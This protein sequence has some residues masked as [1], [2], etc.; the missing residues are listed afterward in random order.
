ML[1]DAPGLA[2][3]KVQA[4]TSTPTRTL[5][6]STSLS[7]TELSPHLSSTPFFSLKTY[8]GSHVLRGT[9]RG[10]V[11]PEDMW[12]E[13]TMQ[14]VPTEAPRLRD[15]TCWGV[16]GAARGPSWLRVVPER[17]NG[18]RSVQGGSWPERPRQDW[19]FHTKSVGRLWE[20]GVRSVP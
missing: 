18:N 19:G 17:K 5:L 13:T 6:L 16:R 9:S 11:W 10:T 7:G 15:E 2:P 14:R 8:P 3:G 4:V 20:A 1:C 12:K